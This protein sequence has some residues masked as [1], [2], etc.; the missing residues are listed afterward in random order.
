MREWIG[1]DEHAVG[2]GG[3]VGSIVDLTDDPLLIL[4]ASEDS[5]L[6][7]RR[8]GRGTVGLL[9]RR[10]EGLRAVPIADL[11]VDR[12]EQA[13]KDLLSE[14]DGETE[15][16]RVAWWHAS[17]RSVP[18]DL[19]C[20]AV[21]TEADQPGIML[22]TVRAAGSCELALRNSVPSEKLPQSLGDL[23]QAKK[24]L[25]SVLD[26]IPDVIGIQDRKHRMIR[27]NRAGLAFLGLESGQEV[28]RR[29]Y[30]LIGRSSPC[31][32]CATSGALR[33]R[34]P[35]QVEKVL[36]DSGICLDCRSYPVLD[37]DG[38]VAY[39]VEH[40]RDV[41]DLKE[42]QER[43]IATEHRLAHGQK[44]EAVG[45]LAG[46][47]AHD[48]NNQLAGIMGYADLLRMELESQPR[49]LELAENV[50]QG[51]RR[52]ADLTAQLLAFARRG[53]YQE[54]D[55]DMHRLIFEVVSMLGHTIDKRIRIERGLAAQPFFIRGDPTQIQNTLLNLALNARDAMPDGGELRFETRN[56]SLSSDDWE[57]GPFEIESGPFL[58]VSVSDTGIGISP[59]VQERMFEPFF[60][61][62]P[63]GK[64]T[65]MGLAAVY[66]TIRHHRGA[67]RVVSQ[68]GRG[69]RFDLF[70][71]SLADVVDCSSDHPNGG[72][73][74]KPR[75]HVLLVDDDAVVRTATR[76]ILERS[77]HVVT[78]CENGREAVEAFRAGW[79]SID[80]VL[81]DM[82]MPEMDGYSTFE[83]LRE[84]D[85]NVV[86]LLF[87][88][89]SADDRVQALLDRGAAGFLPK[90]FSVR[91]L[92]RRLEAALA[93]RDSR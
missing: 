84:V 93:S 32:E 29:C 53:K 92:L 24:L 3:V 23:P 34:R 39:I 47:I 62:K 50:L 57:G 11:F 1:A 43:V 87:S 80:V 51:A 71:P 37:D 76:R 20:Q 42:A 77:G 73:R 70:F 13:V 65:G 59:E 48:F 4:I 88:G 85:S 15:L 26:A 36:E 7:I 45:Q 41:T 10:P 75:R 66:G 25:E 8:A 21:V 30:E 64:G 82:I 58:Q 83:A 81:L 54:V 44:M 89:F 56:V 28:G 9:G 61:T 67:L 5:G 55:L 78:S 49:L 33:T 12:D 72:Q 19:G 22:L 86:V 91:E 14:R 69:S 74:S 18:I 46:G 35:C 2:Q 68:Q 90:P 27:Y 38:R 31:E 63:E 6:V 60:T 40:L 52:S 17:G 79:S 16:V